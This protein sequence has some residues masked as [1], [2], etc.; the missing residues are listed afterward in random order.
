MAQTK[1]NSKTVYEVSVRVMAEV[2][3]SVAADSVQDAV[4]QV[5]AMKVNDIVKPV[6]G[7]MYEWENEG[8]VHVSKTDLTPFKK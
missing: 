8:I 6:R 3:I 5:S 4:N 2:N 7:D 1:A